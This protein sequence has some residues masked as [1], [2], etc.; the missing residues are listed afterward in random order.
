[1]RYPRAASRFR[2]ET[3][4]ARGA[5]IQE[6]VVVFTEREARDALQDIRP[7][8]LACRSRTRLVMW[9]RATSGEVQRSIFT[10]QDSRIWRT[11]AE[12]APALPVWV[13]THK[14]GD[15]GVQRL[16]S[17]FKKHMTSA[18]PEGIGRVSSLLGRRTTRS[19]REGQ[20][21]R[22]E[23]LGDNGDRPRKKQLPCVV[24]TIKGVL[25]RRTASSG[26]A[27]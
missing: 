17:R 7:P 24:A 19:W 22:G 8:K 16:V 2:Q 25:C 27:S 6:L 18:L 26:R 12:L 3:P 1:M 21:R 13:G 15:E 4:A 23:R 10:Y 20:K 9:V 5:G 11:W 14:Y